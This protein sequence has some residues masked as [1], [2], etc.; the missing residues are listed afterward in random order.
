V[1]LLAFVF[2]LTVWAANYPSS[3][4]WK[5]FSFLETKLFD[6][7]VYVG[8]PSVIGDMLFHGVFRVL[9]WV[10]SVM[11][12][13]MAIFFPLF[14]ILEDLGYL[15]RI[16]FNLDNGFKKCSACGKQALTMCMG[17]G[18]NAAGITGCRIIDSKRERL[19]AIITNNFVPCNGRFPTIIAIISMFLVG[20]V[21]G[22]T[23]SFIS[24]MI[25]TFVILLGIA[26]TFLVSRILAATVLKG[27]PS[28]FTLELPP[29]RKPQIGSLIVRSIFDRTVFVL[30]RAMSVAA[31]AGLIIWLFANIT[32]NDI[33]LLSYTSS[34]LDPFGRLLGMDGIILLGFILGFPANEIVI[35]II[36]M[37]YMGGGVLSDYSSLLELKEL[38]VNNGWTLTTAICTI[39]FSLMHWPCSTAVLT[40]K[41]ETGSFYWSFIAFIVPTLCGM[42]LCFIINS[43][44]WLF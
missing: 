41:K 3:L 32:V 11:L 10:V 34:F 4:L 25:L 9:F 22:G 1:L 21:S 28:S 17:F 31:P 27:Q 12:P 29:Y 13:P 8:L 19:I 20:N 35:P 42:L 2:W 44:L 37:A 14:T 40:V 39:I 16:A 30:L 36:I 43:V 18:C 24:A 6:L 15:P 23:G 7:S 33:T 26:A 38:L 5:L